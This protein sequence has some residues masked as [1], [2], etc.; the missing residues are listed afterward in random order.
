MRLPV[1]D[2]GA[3]ASFKES[4]SGKQVLFLSSEIIVRDL[5]GQESFLKVS[6]KPLAGCSLYA[7]QINNSFNLIV[8]QWLALLPQYD[9]FC[10][11]CVEIDAFLCGMFSLCQCGFL[12][13][14]LAPPTVQRR[15]CQVNL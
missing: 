6:P 15:T 9:G 3:A 10:I 1:Y 12:C 5:I 7:H 4:L 2:T 11:F 13:G 14:T 8:G